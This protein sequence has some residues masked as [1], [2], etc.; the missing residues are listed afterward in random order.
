MTIPGMTRLRRPAWAPAVFLA[1]AL[2]ALPAGAQLGRD[3]RWFTQG[4]EPVY[5]VGFD[6]QE[7]ACDPSI[8]FVAA[9]DEFV[10]HRL[11]KVRIWAYAYWNPDG[12]IHPWAYESGTFDLDTWDEAYWARVGEFVAAARDRDI[13]VEFTVF[14]PNNIDAAD[15]WSSAESRPAWNRDFNL[16]GVFTGNA[17][18]DFVPDF[19]DLEHP[20]VSTSGRLLADYQ[21][22]LVQ[23]SLDEL[24]PYDNVYVEVCNEFPVSGASIDEVY[25]WQL[26]WVAFI[27]GADP[28]RLVSVHA[29]EYSGPHA[30]GMPY[31][32]DEPAIDVL[33]VH[34]YETSPQTVSDILHDAQLK[35]KILSN[36]ETGDFYGEN[37]DP[38][39]RLVWG[40]AMAGGHAA[41]Y[42]DDST[43]IGS[44]GW[45]E[46]AVRLEALRDIM[47]SV[48]FRELSPVDAGGGELDDLV[49]S[50]PADGRQVLANPGVQYIV[51]VWGT[52]SSAPL[53]ITL[54][55]GDYVY[56][57]VDVR[58]ASTIAEGD[59]A[60]G[61]PASIEAPSTDDWSGAAG[62]ALVI[63]S[64]ALPVDEGT[65]EIP[66]VAPDE[67]IPDSPA[68]LAH[69]ADGAADPPAQDVDGIEGGGTTEGGCSCRV[70]AAGDSG[71][72]RP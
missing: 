36:N 68:D 53:E 11:N 33:N 27:D 66:D 8:D 30:R 49:V 23:K 28:G 12:F 40:M 72:D 6:C 70:V 26:H 20:E 25:P 31:F 44:D 47:E 5:L 1:A 39:A 58:N 4:G 65:E 10:V 16:N 9:L 19:Y 41:L 14:G 42:E 18:G 32:W 22:D 37:L 61:S 60:G 52:P 71:S 59:A 67:A 2:L 62:A 24:A 45:V 64:S 3:G 46:G 21:Q 55:A 51:Y 57:W 29:H 34:L 69:E 50:A 43:R 17:D 7:L 15:S 48:R 38:Q 63:E 54:P 35:G 13:V 56:R